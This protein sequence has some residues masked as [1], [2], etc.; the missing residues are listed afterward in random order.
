MLTSFDGKTHVEENR[1]KTGQ[2]PLI[3]N[4]DI[5]DSNYFFVLAVALSTTVKGPT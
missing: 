1:L 2:R 3:L 4:I 5:P